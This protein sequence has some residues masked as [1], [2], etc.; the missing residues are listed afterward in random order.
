MIISA[1]TALYDSQLPKEP[2]D[3]GDV[4][5][6]ISSNDPPRST[7]TLFQLLRSE[8]LTSLPPRTISKRERRNRLG[9]LVFTVS[10]GSQN[11]VGSGKKSF[12]VGQLLDFDDVVEEETVSDLLAPNVLELQQNTNKL[13]LESMGLTEEEADLLVSSAEDQ[14]EEAL[15]RYNN[16]KTSIS[17]KEAEISTNQKLINETR[18]AKEA[19]QTIFTATDDSTAGN[20]IVDKLDQKENELLGERV[21]LI[22]QL[23]E[24]NS[25]AN[26]IYNEILDIR[27]VVR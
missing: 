7:S 11:F 16:V 10:I 14:L 27:E 9:E 8:E 13:S 24:L 26:E 23:D 19:A 22:A 4:I 3:G 17:N 21:L 15:D 12:E 20:M 18:K 5:F 2:D 25:N 6:T 1:P